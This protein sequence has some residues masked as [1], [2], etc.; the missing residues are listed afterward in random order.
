[1]MDPIIKVE[2]LKKHFGDLEVLDD[3]DFSVNK[4]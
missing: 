4:D 3:I 1:M 2:H